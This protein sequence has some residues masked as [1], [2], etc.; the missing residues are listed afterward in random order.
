M[1][2]C[3]LFQVPERWHHKCDSVMVA[4]SR[5]GCSWV[6]SLLLRVLAAIILILLLPSG[7]ATQMSTW[8][9]WYQKSRPLPRP[10]IMW[11][12]TWDAHNKL[13]FVTKRKLVVTWNLHLFEFLLIFV[14]WNLTLKD[15]LEQRRG[16]LSVR[17]CH[18]GGWRF[19]LGR[20]QYSFLPPLNIIWSTCEY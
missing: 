17:Q 15:Y 12:E 13:H 10:S 4:R 7:I 2:L 6:S 9:T 1:Y 11:R 18:L 14:D 19:V 8:N 16:T 3:V 5:V 20:Q